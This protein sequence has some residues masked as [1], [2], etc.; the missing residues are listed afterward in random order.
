M[1]LKNTASLEQSRKL[2][3]SKGKEELIFFQGKFMEI[4]KYFPIVVTSE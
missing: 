4:T 1:L 2:T 3:K